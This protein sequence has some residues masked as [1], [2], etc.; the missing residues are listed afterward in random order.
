MGAKMNK[1]KLEFERLKEDGGE[2]D[3]KSFLRRM[4][5]LAAHGDG[6]ALEFLAELMGELEDSELVKQRNNNI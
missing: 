2:N 1:Y 3:L 5:E 4:Y 6:E